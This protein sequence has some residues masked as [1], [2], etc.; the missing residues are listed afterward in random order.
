MSDVT[1]PCNH[2]VDEFNRK[3]DE[4]EINHSFTMKEQPRKNL[5][6][7]VKRFRKSENRNVCILFNPISLPEPC[8]AGPITY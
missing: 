2:L 1:T 5:D 6:V 3:D 4:T 8:W 7:P